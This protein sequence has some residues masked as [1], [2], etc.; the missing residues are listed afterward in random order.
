V[1]VA[2][3][4]QRPGHLA[5]PRRRGGLKLGAQPVDVGEDLA[6]QRPAV[7]ALG[8]VGAQHVGQPVLLAPGLLQVIFQRLRERLDLGGPG[9]PGDPGGPGDPGDRRVGRLG[10]LGIGLD[11]LAVSAHRRGQLGDDRGQPGSGLRVL[12]RAVLAVQPCAV[13]DGAGQH[14]QVGGGSLERVDAVAQAGRRVTDP[15]SPRVQPDA[16]LGLGERVVQPLDLTAQRPGTV[17]PFGGAPGVGIGGQP[18]RHLTEQVGHLAAHVADCV[19]GGLHPQRCEDQARGQ[20]GG[21]ANQRFRDAAGGGGVR[22]HSEDQHR[23]DRYLQGVRAEPEHQAERE[24]ARDEQSEHPPAERD[25]RGDRDR[26]DHADG[27]ADDPLDGAADGVEQGGLR[28]EQRGQRGEH[29]P[30]RRPG[31]LQREQVREHRREG[32]PGNVRRGR[33]RPAA[34]QRELLGLALGDRPGGLADALARHGTK[35]ETFHELYLGVWWAAGYV[36]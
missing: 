21:R 3:Q 20:P 15:Q 35:T 10:G 22:V 23:A 28:H 31:E 17:Q 14:A 1:P 24:R 25:V 5:L 4:P 6:A 29:G 32:E 7:R 16:L 27:D 12:D 34:D 2:P 36:G 9:D 8:R 13:G 19:L 11:E 30:G 33:L 26:G 18:V